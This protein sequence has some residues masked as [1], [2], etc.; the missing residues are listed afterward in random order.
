MGAP[1][2]ALIVCAGLFAPEQRAERHVTKK[3]AGICIVPIEFEIGGE[4][5]AKSAQPLQ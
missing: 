2:G 1:K 5:P 4:T 3:L